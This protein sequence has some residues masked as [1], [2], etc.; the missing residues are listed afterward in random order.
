M[1]ALSV[2]ACNRRLGL[3]NGISIALAFTG[4]SFVD[5]D[6]AV[7]RG[8]PQN[9]ILF[10]ELFEYFNLICFQ[11]FESRFNGTNLALVDVVTI[12]ILGVLMA[13]ISVSVLINFSRE[14][15][16]PGIV[17]LR[18][19]LTYVRLSDAPL[20]VLHLLRGRIF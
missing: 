4:V 12:S 19:T 6:S 14:G 18:S 9:F 16:T 8:V 20:H 7:E 3:R 15:V 2:L 1:P 10:F 13:G 11:F 17:D 5:K